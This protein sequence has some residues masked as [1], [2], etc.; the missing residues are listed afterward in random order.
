M[1]AGRAL[2]S[3]CHGGL[4]RSLGED[5]EQ[6]TLLV[7]APNTFSC[8]GKQALVGPKVKQMCLLCLL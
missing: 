8:F 5:N 1:L 6:C 3:L 2:K 4:C 7:V